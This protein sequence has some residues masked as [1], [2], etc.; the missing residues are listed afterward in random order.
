MIRKL[1]DMDF[2]D[3]RVIVRID[4]DVPLDEGKIVDDTRLRASVDTINF[5]IKRGAKQIFLLGHLG[6][7]KG[8]P[9]PEL[10]SKP[11]AEWFK[12]QEFDVTHVDSC[13]DIDVPE[14]KVVVLE[15]VRFYPEEKKNDE[16][17]AKK[18]ASLADVYVNNAFATCHREHASMVGIPKYIPG[19]IGLTVQKELDNLTIENPEKPYVAIVGGAKLET[20]LPVIQN[21]LPKVD[22]LLVGGGMIFTFYKAKGWEIGASLLDETSLQMANMIGDNDKLVLPT[23]VVVADG[24]DDGT[25]A[26][27]VI[28][29]GI[30]IGKK[31]LDIGPESVEKFKEIMDAAKTIV[32][33]GPLGYV[34]AEP[35]DKATVEIADHMASLTE[36]GVRTII[37][38]GDSVKIINKLGL[39][40]KFTH[41][42]TGGGASLVL[43]QGDKLVALE[44]LE[45]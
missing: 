18:L 44:A 15:N 20:K 19:C 39:A 2:K 29:Q 37:G 36:K 24:P 26:K 16:E 23:D 1:S 40:G 5:I 33:N 43:L 3:K 21:L 41:V 32:W 11:I 27:T 12:T 28:A 13:I 10:S 34:E 4:M 7:P 6:R 17:F 31:G 45:R 35:F 14:S 30:P 9:V 42:S 22:Y 25:N 38:G 8:V